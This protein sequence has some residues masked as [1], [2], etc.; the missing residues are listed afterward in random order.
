MMPDSGDFRFWA[1]LPE[2]E[3]ER[4]RGLYWH[5]VKASLG[6][7]PRAPVFVDK[8]P[9]NAVLL[10]LIYRLFPHSRIILALRDP[11]DTVLSCFQQRFV[12]NEAMYP[13][14]R[15]DSAVRFYDGV[16]GVVQTCRE[17]LGLPFHAIRYE[18]VVADFDQEI[19]KLLTFV[20]LP[21]DDRVRDF[22]A[23]A[24]LRMVNTPSA[25]QV[26]MPLYSS[27]VGKWRNYASHTAP[28]F[29]VLAPWVA[30]F[31]YDP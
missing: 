6:D 27:S 4:L 21:W 3:I 8:L 22:A 28:F 5:S 24:R 15:L 29:P 19:G 2:H 10:P 18:D 23:T 26:V 31:G 20:N 17:R 11:R 1:N 7:M 30:T 14:L 9:L 12:I 25:T 13:L 16:M